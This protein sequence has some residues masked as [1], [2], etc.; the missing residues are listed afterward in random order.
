[1]LGLVGGN[2]VSRADGHMADL[3][4]DLLGI[5][6][7]NTWGTDR[8]HLLQSNVDKISRE[9]P[10][11]HISINATPVSLPAFQQWAYPSV[12]GPIPLEK[13]TCVKPEKF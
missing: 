1:M 6:R 13:L 11:I 7:P 4:S 9:N 10:K 5:T 2:E 12:I 3:E 8:Q